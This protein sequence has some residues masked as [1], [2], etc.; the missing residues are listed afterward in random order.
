VLDLDRVRAAAPTL[1]GLRDFGAFCR[2][3]EGATTVRTLLDLTAERV[4]DGP[5]AGTVEVTVRADAFCHSMVRSL[6]G[7]LVG[8]GSGHRDLGWLAAV[9]ATAARASDVQVLPA[10]GLTL[11]EVGYPPD[12]ELVERSRAARSVRELSTR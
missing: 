7:A 5:L 10:R 2:R 8:V 3:R 4:A 11:E 9:A 6:V 1:L 12:D